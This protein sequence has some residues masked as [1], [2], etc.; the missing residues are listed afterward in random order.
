VK[1]LSAAV[2]AV[3]AGIAITGCST[4]PINVGNDPDILWW[5]DL[6]SGSTSD[7]TAR[8]ATYGEV[9]QSGNTM[10]NVTAAGPA[11][12]GRYALQATLTATF[13]GPPARAMASRQ[14]DLPSEGYY[15][16]WFY[17]P[18][19]ATPV[20]YWTCFEFLSRT[21]PTDPTTVVAVWDID[22]TPA[23]LPGPPGSPV[24]GSTASILEV[25][26]YAQ[27]RAT[28]G[29]ASPV[30]IGQWFQIEAFFRPAPDT[31]GRLTVWQDGTLV[32][33]VTGAAT[34]PTSFAEWSVGSAADALTPST[35]NL[36]IDDVAI[37]RRRLGPTF[38]P[39]WRP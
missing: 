5:S 35:V 25:F 2:A 31:T 17:I 9:W 14:G 28:R 12:S 26:S 3:A 38:P 37:S 36:F 34:A 30:P 4:A 23:V 22:L 6:E 8:G 32:I 1:R 33:D 7:W 27:G 16:G 20:T 15:S 13:G 29:A 21:T 10:L 18:V 24:S 19:N 11:R 39:F